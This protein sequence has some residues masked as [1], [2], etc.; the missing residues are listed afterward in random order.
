MEQY[1]QLVTS[2]APKDWDKW[3]TIASA[4]HNNRKNQ[5]TGLLPNQ[6]L[7]GY[8]TPLTTP[9]DVETKNITIEQHVEIINQRRDQAIKA[10][11]CTA[12]QTGTPLAQYKTG[13]QV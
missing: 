6:I 10:L 7:I 4:V 13:Y 2:A 1:L 8:K 3:L 12:E 9:N 5:T 11:N